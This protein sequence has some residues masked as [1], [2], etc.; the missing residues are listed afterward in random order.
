MSAHVS[1]QP[2]HPP[3]QPGDPTVKNLHV[4]IPVP[5]DIPYIPDEPVNTIYAV[6]ESRPEPVQYVPPRSEPIVVLGRHR[7]PNTQ[8]YYPPAA[9][10]QGIEGVAGVR[11]CVD[12]NGRRT[13]DP[14]IAESS[15]S[16]LLDR[17]AIELARD[18]RYARSAQGGRPVPNCH[19]FR[20]RFE[21][22]N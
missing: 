15:G 12:E 19:Q 9:I 5:K 14:V 6:P 3:P 1:A 22:K 20:V 11:V 18:G 4:E 13:G 8:D 17:G 2:D 7:L 21:L 10:R 16:A